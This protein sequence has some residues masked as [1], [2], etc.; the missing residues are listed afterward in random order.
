M[1][2]LAPLALAL[3]LGSCITSNLCAQV[4][5]PPAGGVQP[6]AP[7]GGGGGLAPWTEWSE[8]SNRETL[9]QYPLLKFFWCDD[10]S[11]VPGTRWIKVNGIV[12][13]SSFNYSA[14]APSGGCAARASSQ[15]TSVALNVGSNAIE[16][17][18]CDDDERGPYC[19]T[20][21][22]SVTRLAGPRPVVSLAPYS[23]AL[24]DLGRCA[25]DCFAATYALS[26]VPYYTLDTPRSVTLAYHGDRLDPKP[27]VQVDVT[28]GGDGSNLPT[29]YRLKVKRGATDITFLNG[30]T[31]LR[32][33]TSTATE[34]LAGQFD[35]AAN[36][37]SADSVYDLTVAV[38]AEYSAGVEWVN[39]STTL[40]VVN[41]N[42]SP[43]AKGWTLAGVQRL[44]PTA[45]GALLTDGTG[46]AVYFTGSGT[47]YYAPAG[48][49]TRLTAS[50]SGTSRT[51]LRAYPDST[52]VTFNFLGRMT[53]I[54][55]RFSNATS[56]TY[57]GSN[58][59]SQVTDPASKAI[60]LS[61]GTYGLATV[62]GFG[63]TTTLTVDANRH[64]TA[65]VD[66]DGDSTRFGYDGAH[67]L[68]TI[69]NR[70]GATTTL[71]YHSTS[72]K[73]TSV[74]APTVTLY[75][76][77]QAQPATTLA[78]W[79]L[80]S[81]PYASTSGTPFTAARAD[82]VRAAVTD[83]A[84]HAARF[85][86]NSFGQPLQTTGPLGDTVTVTYNAGGQPLT[87]TDR[88]GVNASY[89]YDNSGFQ[90]RAIVAGDTTN[91]HSGGWA[92]A[93][94][95]WGAGPR[96]LFGI[97]TNGRVDWTSIDGVHQVYYAYDSRGRVTSRHGFLHLY[98]GP[99]D[100][101]QTDSIEGSAR[102]TTYQD[103]GWGR[104]VQV[105]RQGFPAATTTLDA[106][107]RP[108][109]THDGV[110]ADSTVFGYDALRLRSVT[111][112]KGQ[113][114]Q[115][116]YNALGWLAS[117]VDPAGRRD[118]FAYDVEGQVRRMINRRG[119]VVE[120]TYDALHRRLARTGNA[121]LSDTLSYSGDGDTV[122][123]SNGV[124]LDS[125]F[126]N[127]RLQPERVRTRFRSPG[128]PSRVYE[129]R[130]W[131]RAS[132]GLLDSVTATG[133][134]L[135][136]LSR[137]YGYRPSRGTLDSVRFGAG[138]W[139]R[140]H[141]NE[142]L[143]VD[144][145]RFPNN[146]LLAS[147]Y[148]WADELDQ[149]ASPLLDYRYGRDTQGRLK[150]AVDNNAYGRAFAYDS[151]GQLRSVRF[152]PRDYVPCYDDSIMGWQCGLYV[153]STI[154]FT[155]DAVGNRTLRSAP[156]G[157][158]AGTYGTG[159]R[160]ASYGGC[161]YGTDDDGN[162]TSRTCGSETVTFSWGADGRLTGYRITGGDSVALRYDAAGRLARRDV[163]GSP[164]SYFLWE[165]EQL[166]AELD[167]TQY[168]VAQYSYYPGLDQLHAFNRGGSVSYAQQDVE[169]NVR[170]L[171]TNAINQMRSY[172]YDESGNLVGGTDWG[173]LNGID[174]ARWKGALFLAPEAG[175][176]YMRARWYEPRSG[177]FLSEDP[178]GMGGG[179]NP[180]VFAGAD[181][182][183]G[184][185][186]TGAYPCSGES[187]HRDG[188]WIR[189]EWLEATWVDDGWHDCGQPY[190]PS[191][192]QRMNECRDV[193]F[194][195]TG[196][197][198][199]GNPPVPPP[200]STQS[201]TALAAEAFASG[202]FDLASWVILPLRGFRLAGSAALRGAFAR[203]L[204]HNGVRSLAREVG[205]ESAG[206]A[207]AARLARRS[208]D[209]THVGG[210]TLH[211]GMAT[212]AGEGW[213]EV[214]KEAFLPGYATG[215]LAWA[216]AQQ[217]LN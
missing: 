77:Q 103:D 76:G 130:Y 82:T 101:L 96:Q 62:W 71:G 47:T 158:A 2:R 201:C 199:T 185:D 198:R 206:L 136:L 116:N 13:T 22:W 31:T 36:G 92:Q 100:N 105:Q 173:N 24:Q 119:Q 195:G 212:Q 16:M 144:T 102:A 175:L 115:M 194:G 74:T 1:R 205:R 196:V 159:D 43:V 21:S 48:E 127:S 209:L 11:L 19:G 193:V 214:A 126:L 78:P 202:A 26:T 70:G 207:T 154:A 208:S 10:L 135:T 106:L 132:N 129:R 7:G 97:G 114:W 109:A 121:I 153:D 108:R 174:R 85:T 187:G 20:S 75:T 203:A 138:A 23:A 140:L 191:S 40:I 122:V 72:G 30:E 145:T 118:S 65:L 39:T 142:D 151:L 42:D 124:A 156:G 180:Y 112:P 189:G 99:R 50:G 95:I 87:T 162:V 125:T 79:Q 3:L 179:L 204:S 25:F 134:S 33:T 5:R 69:T 61:Y 49:F 120:L 14:E 38:G 217:C 172:T 83:P 8:P 45:S 9:E 44:Y 139:T 147:G 182:V 56:F 161:S 215:K 34:R 188:H 160:I 171:G 60:Y 52:R 177:R 210:L 190:D 88:L 166:L 165:G 150:T 123:A 93:D 128:D 163:N 35:G 18:I 183:N 186:P 98:G 113:T 53:E 54:R 27:F 29:A 167:G 213:F 84:G 28:H 94:S 146:D 200:Q 152:G 170:Y 57:D 41:E 211:G 148:A 133:P 131:Y 63:P 110:N 81:V 164:A 90:T 181:G 157:D 68:A 17:Y 66:P 117:R 143:Q 37:M 176:Y 155:H 6:M 141:R 111:D 58:R 80:V 169:G 64:L 91:A 67:R 4:G 12:R 32:F 73:L 184:S 168:L 178:A 86:I 89:T 149:L 192:L 107:G 137:G 51:Y 55:D 104:V 216:W 59:L 15:T 197:C 46:S